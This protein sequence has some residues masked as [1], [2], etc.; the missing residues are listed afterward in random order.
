MYTAPKKNLIYTFSDWPSW[1]A[2]RQAKL[3]I[4]YFCEQNNSPNF[5]NEGK[6]TPLH[7]ILLKEMQRVTLFSD[8]RPLTNFKTNEQH[9]AP[10][11]HRVLT[12]EESKI[13]TYLLYGPKSPACGV[14]WRR[15]LWK[16]E[17]EMATR[18]ATTRRAAVRHR[19][20]WRWRIRQ[21]EKT[22]SHSVK[23]SRST[24]K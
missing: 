15:K 7:D 21:C 4:Y 3:Y 10:V 22:Y 12:Q 14:L 2:S 19:A 18:G 5:D 16:R 8:R 13:Y 1:K 9:L 17:T 23:T 20:N 24:K 11:S 6:M